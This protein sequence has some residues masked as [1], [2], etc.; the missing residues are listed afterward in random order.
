[1]LQCNCLP[2]VVTISKGNIWFATIPHQILAPRDTI[3][4]LYCRWKVER[5][6]QWPQNMC[7]RIWQCILQCPCLLAAVTIRITRIQ[8][9]TL[10]PELVALQN[11][12]QD[13]PGLEE[14]RLG[15]HR[16]RVLGCACLAQGSS[17]QY[18]LITWFDGVINI[19]LAWYRPVASYRQST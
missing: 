17:M 15:Q 2:A 19:L 3:K 10:L 6:S 18:T 4:A 13:Q 11:I 14:Y 7:M 12:S 16:V 8:V 1:M 5:P 9:A